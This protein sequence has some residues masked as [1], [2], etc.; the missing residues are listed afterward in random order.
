MGLATRQKA[1]QAASYVRPGYGRTVA[2]CSV[3]GN[4]LGDWLV[5]NGWAVAYYLYSY[6]YTRAEHHAKTN[7][8]GL[9]AGEF[10][11]PWDWRRGKRLNSTTAAP[12]QPPA[13]QAC[14]KICRKGKAC[15]NSC[16]AAWKTCPKGPGCACNAD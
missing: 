14:C 9:W 1:E 10:V 8:L 11:F 3:N 13:V 15:G 4:G 7:R 5:R 6:E 12:Q 2:A 16:I